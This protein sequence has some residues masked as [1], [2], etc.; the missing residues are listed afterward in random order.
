MNDHRTSSIDCRRSRRYI[1]QDYLLIWLHNDT[2]ETNEEYQNTLKHLRNLVDTID[3]FTNPDECVNFFTEFNDM[4]TFLIINDTISE[5][6]IPLIHDLPQLDQ[7]YIFSRTTLLSSEWIGKWTKIKGISAEM[8]S[9]CATLKLMIRQHNQDSIA[10]S[11]ISLNEINPNKN[12]N[13]LESTFMYSQIFKNILLKMNYNDNSIDEFV[14]F[15]QK[16]KFGSPKNIDLFEKE[17]HNRSSI[18]WYTWPGFIYPMLNSSLRTLESDVIIKMG[19]FIYD[20]HKQIEQLYNDQRDSYHE[21]SLKVYRGQGLSKEHFEKVIKAKNGLISFNNFLSTSKVE[22]VSVGF[23]VS[24]STIADTVGILFVIS[25][26]PSVSSAPFACIQKHSYFESEE[27]ILFSMHTVFRIGD[28]KR[29]DNNDELYRIELQLTADNDQELCILTDWLSKD[30]PD[31]IGWKRLGNLLIRIGQLEKAEQF[32]QTLLE[33]TSD[34]A[35]MIHYYGQLAFIKYNQGDRK[36]S[37]WYHLK[38]SELS[39]TTNSGDSTDELTMVNRN[40]SEDNKTIVSYKNDLRLDFGEIC[41][42]DIKYIEY[43]EEREVSPD[44]LSFYEKSLDD[45]QR[46]LRLKNLYPTTSCNPFD[47][48]DDH[49]KQSSPLLWFQRKI[50][51]IRQKCLHP[52]HPDI[53]QSYASVASLYEK[54]KDPYQARSFYQK[55]IDICKQILPSNHPTLSCLYHN[56]GMTYQSTGEYFTALCFI[57]K[58]LEIAEKTL[59]PYHLD[60]SFIYFNMAGLYDKLDDYSNATVYYKNS[61]IVN[62]KNPHIKDEN[63]TFSCT[64]VGKIHSTMKQYSEALIYYNKAL[65]IEE[66]LCP[67]DDPQLIDYYAEIASLH[68]K[69]EEYPNALLFFHKA[70]HIVEKHLS[71]EFGKLF[72]LYDA[73]ARSYEKNANYPQALLFYEKTLGISEQ[74][75]TLNHINSA[76]CYNN[77]GIVYIRMGQYSKALSY[78]E[79]ALHMR[80]I[81]NPEDDSRWKEIQDAID[82]LR[83]LEDED[84]IESAE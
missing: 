63:Y 65:T 13:E 59:P 46:N 38:I 8:T 53:A 68:H 71:S 74:M 29:I 9:L 44:T 23:A 31:E 67:L 47:P 66:Q 51:E 6:I 79:L 5:Q 43:S 73:I 57:K 70:L 72:T 75:Y 76:V 22:E 15:C 61:I 1:A 4:K 41:H 45:F 21:E 40:F 17:Y 55:S 19:F 82:Y 60:L 30:V 42:C 14:Q 35:D 16:N 58:S 78:F 25:I 48:V 12:L 54:R 56:I 20:L 27:E 81:C 37:M 50:L 33:Q 18:W 34:V 39:K 36:M 32:Y 3:I 10:T 11:V 84:V 24:A 80:Q 64:K 28:V 49:L 77:I 69:L 7:I 83:E 52:N 2:N 26:D 62:E